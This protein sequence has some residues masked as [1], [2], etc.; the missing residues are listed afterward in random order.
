[1]PRPASA[2]RAGRTGRW[3]GTK[4]ILTSA[5][6]G[7]LFALLAP[8][9]R[10]Q[11]FEIWNGAEVEAINRA[12]LQLRIR[13]EYRSS[14]MYRNFQSIRGIVE[15]RVPISKHFAATGQYQSVET[16]GNFSGW[17][18]YNRASGGAE[19]PFESRN[20]TVTPRVAV[21]HF[22]YAGRTDYN[23]HRERVVVRMKNLLFQPQIGAEI[24]AD[25]KGWAATRI[26]T[27][28]IFPVYRNLILD[29]GYYYDWR[30]PNQGGDRHIV[31]T[32]FR[33]RRPRG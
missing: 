16:H 28:A 9:A 18:E 17:D 19:F 7:L 31:Y 27:G 12:R 24:F 33:L 26:I 5:L 6:P 14:D 21:D 29:A 30:P 10:A 22:W 4:R 32:F 20:L 25:S 1:M 8:S 3:P 13:G 15:A 11:S 23:R 2:H